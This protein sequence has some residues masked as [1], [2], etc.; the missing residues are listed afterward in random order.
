MRIPRISKILAR[1]MKQKDLILDSPMGI[2]SS[3]NFEKD[4]DQLSAPEQ[5]VTDENESSGNT[6]LG[7]EMTLSCMLG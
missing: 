2:G 5:L 6:E 4:G 1:K 7:G 3:Q